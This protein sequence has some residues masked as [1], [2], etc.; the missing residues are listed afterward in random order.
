MK[1]FGLGD[2]KRTLPKI[3]IFPLIK[4]G[5]VAYSYGQAVVQTVIQST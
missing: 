3:D 1:V 2:I 4:A 5:F